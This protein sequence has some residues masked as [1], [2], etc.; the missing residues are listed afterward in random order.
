MPAPVLEHAIATVPCG[1]WAV[2]VSG[3]ADSAA[4]LSLLRERNDLSLHV[5]HL[6]H[7]TRGDESDADAAFVANLASQWNLPCTIAL[8]SEI[9]NEPQE[10]NPSARYRAARREL[11]R[12]VVEQ[13]QLCGVILAHHAD[14][15]A[16]TV[17]HR[18][19]RGSSWRGL[20][21]MQP[22]AQFGT[23]AVLRPMLDVPRNALRSYLTD[24][25]QAWREDPSNA[26]DKYERN[27]LRRFLTAHPTL[28]AD[29]LALCSSCQVLRQWTMEH[30]VV[31]A[32]SFA[33]KDLADLPD[34]LAMES[35]R[36]WLVDRGVSAANADTG[37]AARLLQMARDAGSSPRQQLAA[38]LVARRRGGRITI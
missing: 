4:L 1:A 10:S 29:L 21:G 24:T 8:L 34:V 13:Q 14:D 20:A 22:K 5:I 11:F 30:A 35:C 2:G 31:L 27:Q 7:Q 18:L 33:T 38:H 19:L 17:L 9:E 23:L 26:S 36:R 3:G 28:T 15:Q 16:E 25:Q 37:A 32:E 6:N 12:R